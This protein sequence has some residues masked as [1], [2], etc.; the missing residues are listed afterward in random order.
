[1][2]AMM[3]IALILMIREFSRGFA[4]R[5]FIYSCGFIVLVIA[6][7]GLSSYP[8]L[9]F[10]PQLPQNSL[11]VYNAASSSKTL[12]LMLFIAL[13]GIYTILTIAVNLHFGYAGLMS[14]GIVGF[15]AVGAYTY[16][17]VTVGPP[18]GEDLYHFGF[19]MRGGS[20]PRGR[21]SDD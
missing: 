4:L 7:Y 10:S 9:V 8:Y 17:I 11:T 15:L 6:L 19:N 16:A 5:A 21:R 2:L 18:V 14:F 3:I 20:F 1:M 13:I 12:R